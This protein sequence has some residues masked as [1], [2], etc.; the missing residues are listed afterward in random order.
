MCEILK[1]VKIKSTKAEGKAMSE[2][3]ELKKTKVLISAADLQK[4][5]EELGQ[6]INKDYQGKAVTAICILKGGVVFFADV[7]RS[8]SIPTKCEFIGCSSYGDGTKSSGEVKLT[9]DT[10]EPIEGRHVIVFEDIVDSGLTLSYLIKL[11]EARKPASLKVCTLLFKPESLKTEFKPDYYGF[12]IG[13][14]FVVGYGLDYAGLYRG[15][16]YIGVLSL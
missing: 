14:E 16:P 1:N 12:A 13:N 6:Q 15:L 11:L 8:L 7:I 5:V 3:V 9:H 10:N 4:R 2:V